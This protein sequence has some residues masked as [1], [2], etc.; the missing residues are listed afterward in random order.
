MEEKYGEFKI[1]YDERVEKFVACDG[2]GGEIA[3]SVKL[4]GLKKRLER[5]GVVRKGFKRFKVLSVVA[6]NRW[7]ENKEPRIVEHEVTSVVDGDRCWL[8]NLETKREIE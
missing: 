7:N 2:N 4:A 8:T 3:S 6:R 5:I 1:K